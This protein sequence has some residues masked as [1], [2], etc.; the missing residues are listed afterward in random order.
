[1]ALCPLRYKRWPFDERGGTFHSRVPTRW[2]TM[3]DWI[4][5]IDHRTMRG[6]WSCEMASSGIGRRTVCRLPPRCT[7][8][9]STWQ[10]YNSKWTTACAQARSPCTVVFSCLFLIWFIHSVRFFAVASHHTHT[11]VSGHFPLFLCNA[12][13]HQPIHIQQTEEF[14]WNK[15]IANKM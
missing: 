3:F 11:F 13:P 1:M 5:A 12:V 4:Y 8:T 7:S 15:K 14:E 6:K 2:N 9:S 10:T